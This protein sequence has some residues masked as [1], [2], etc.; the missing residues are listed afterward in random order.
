LFLLKAPTQQHHEVRAKGTDDRKKN[1]IQDR[2][3][4]DIE[5]E[6]K[7]APVFLD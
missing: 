3:Q 6:P 2:H 7:G 5:R 1:K 4:A